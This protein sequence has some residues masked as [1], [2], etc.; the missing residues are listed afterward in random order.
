MNK[1]LLITVVLVVGLVIWGI[2]KYRARSSAADAPPVWVQAVTVKETTIPLEARAIGTLVAARNVKITPEVA[3]H[4]QK[5]LFH[6]GVTVKQGAPLIQ[7]DDAVFKAQYESAKAKLSYSENNFKRMTILGKQGAIAKQAIDQ[8]D[9]DLKEKRADAQQAAVML[10]KMQLLAPFDGIMGKRTINPGDYVT[11]GQALV[12]ITD[13]KH[14]HIEYSIPEKYLPLLKLNQ[15]V[16]ITTAAYPDQLFIGKVAYVS[17][18]INV[19]SRSVSLYAE[20]P[21]EKNLLAPGMFVSIVHSLGT[22]DHALMVPARSLIPM[23]DAEQVYKVV[24]GKAYAV[25][26]AVGKRTDNM[27][28]ITKGLSAGDV[29]ITDGQLKVKTGMPVKIKN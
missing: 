22:I 10:E 28:Q 21:N 27:V 29:V 26:V 18:T 13:V 23:M 12:S 4:V 11:V 19:D 9:A 1:K 6:D 8:A 16:Q 3:G 14:L 5:I 15:E 25:T 20:V 7:L 24:N 2:T 17:P